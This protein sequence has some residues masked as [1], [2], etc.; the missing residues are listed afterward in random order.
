MNVEWTASVE[1]SYWGYLQGLIVI[2][3]ILGDLQ[4]EQFNE[5]GML[6]LQI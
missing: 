6:L 3:L 5:N 4:D 2:W 1:V